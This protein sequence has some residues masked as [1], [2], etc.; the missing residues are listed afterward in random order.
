MSMVADRKQSANDRRPPT[1]GSGPR[2]RVV[3][4]GL[5]WASRYGLLAFLVG[6]FVVFSILR[7]DSFPTRINVISILSDQSVIF[8]AA[9]AVMLPLIVGEFDLSVA[10]NVSL[11]NTFVLG[12]G[13]NQG[14]PL[15]PAI[16]MAIL[17]STIVGV[18]NGV[19]VTRFKVNAF[20]GTLGMATLLG[21]IQQLYTGG[22]DII[23]PPAGLTSIARTDVLG[24][25]LSVYY[26]VIV[27]LVVYVVLNHL[28]LGRKMLAVGGSQR[29]AALTGIPVERYR[30]AAFAA[31]GLLAGVGGV[32]LGAQ[33]GTASIAGN[34]DL[35]LPVFTAALLGAT[36]ITPGRYNV[37]GTAIA[38]LFL[39]VTVSG[40]QQLGVSTW[41]EP[42][43]DG[44]ALIV[45]VAISGWA[46]RAR[47]ARARREQLRALSAIDEPVVAETGEVI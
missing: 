32:I 39:A 20:V 15:V 46:A 23:T 17:A 26:A 18:L 37:P 22:L 28:T 21:G 12:F 44:A 11:A 6:L 13:V 41:V 5:N 9:L 34:N 24:I 7:P 35:L 33:I 2:A 47:A 43:F 30:I 10:A 40:L 42:T 14:I 19:A 16:A 8:I 25:P 31:G 38:V 3:S 4:T 27:G 36:V 29:A 45:A 1:D